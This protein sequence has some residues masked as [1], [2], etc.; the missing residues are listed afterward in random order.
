MPVSNGQRF[1]SEEHA[2]SNSSEFE[3]LWKLQSMVN[4]LVLDGRRTP[5]EV[6]NVL[7]SVIN[8]PVEQFALLT[9][10]GII[11]VPEDYVHSSQLAIFIA[12]HGQEFR[13]YNHSIT[14]KD[15]GNPTRILKPGDRLRV[16]TYRQI[17][18]G[19]TTYEERIA[20]LNAIGMNSIYPGAQGLT[21][22]YEQKYGMLSPGYVYTSFDHQTQIPILSGKRRVSTLAKSPND[23]Y[24][25]LLFELER[26]YGINDAFFGFSTVE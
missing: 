12:K 21:L 3:R 8:G 22:V 20:F 6:A 16:R 14:D 11:T 1:F 25:F 26:D 19:E 10:L 24:R 9:D 18:P 7:Q 17:V 23:D 2:M 15:Y 4:K 13:L 5:N